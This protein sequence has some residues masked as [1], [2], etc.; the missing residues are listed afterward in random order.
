MSEYTLGVEKD[1]LKE[2]YENAT[3]DKKDFLLVD[4]DAPVENRFR[5]NFNQI[6]DV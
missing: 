3:H 6:Y 2:I 4:L 5:K 1:Q